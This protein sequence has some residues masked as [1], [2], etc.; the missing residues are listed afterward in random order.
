[1]PREAWLPESQPRPQRRARAARLLVL[2]VCGRVFTICRQARRDRSRSGATQQKG[3]SAKAHSFWCF[4]L[5]KGTAL[6]SSQVFGMPGRVADYHLTLC[7]CTPVV[8]DSQSNI[9]SKLLPAPGPVESPLHCTRKGDRHVLAADKVEGASCR[10]PWC[11][12][13]ACGAGPAV[14]WRTHVDAGIAG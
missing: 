11:Q 6:L 1:M 13:K 4:L 10:H 5:C 7:K 14:H 3:S 2:T 9:P 12:A 8:V